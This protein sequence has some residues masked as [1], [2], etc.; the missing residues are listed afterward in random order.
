MWSY[1]MFSSFGCMYKKGKR[2]TFCKAHPELYPANTIKLS[3]NPEIWHLVGLSIG[4]NLQRGDDFP[5]PHM[6]P[7]LRFGAPTPNWHTPLYC[8]LAPVKSI[9]SSS[10]ARTCSY[11]SIY[12]LIHV[13]LHI[14]GFP[15][16]VVPNNQGFPTKNDHFG[17][18]WGYHHLRKHPYTSIGPEDKGSRF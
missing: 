3:R 13:L 2:D 8:S 17:A 10:I 4:H 11:F 15:K 16:M 9:E 14:W 1:H 5:I 18:F 12:W 7:K 6:D